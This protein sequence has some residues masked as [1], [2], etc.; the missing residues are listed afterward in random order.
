MQRT[1]E[2]MDEY[3]KGL[4]ESYEPEGGLWDL[5]CIEELVDVVQM[6]EFPED[7]AALERFIDQC[8]QPVTT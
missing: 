3:L 5:D 6:T 4:L 7:T 1:V 8:N 2:E